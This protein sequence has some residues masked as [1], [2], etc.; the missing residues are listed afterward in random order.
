[1]LLFD[2]IS[3][4]YFVGEGDA[5]TVVAAGTGCTIISSGH[6]SLDGRCMTDCN[7]ETIARR[8]LMK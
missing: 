5:G 4:S 3:M 1:M 7:A 2:L 6:V 8:C